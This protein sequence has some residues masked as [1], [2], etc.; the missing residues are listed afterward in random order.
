MTTIGE[1]YRAAKT[2]T[3]DVW[4]RLAIVY[5][6]FE[7]LHNGQGDALYGAWC[8]LMRAYSPSDQD[9]LEAHCTAAYARLTAGLTEARWYGMPTRRGQ[10][11][12]NDCM[13]F[14]TVEAA[15][16]WAERHLEFGEWIDLYDGYSPGYYGDQFP[17][18]RIT[19]PHQVRYE[20]P[21]LTLIETF[22]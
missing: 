17:D 11:E 5:A 19:A 21:D 9:L 18:L 2:E 22:S 13:A 3:D 14:E 16:E 4:E 7:S 15:Q 6:A 8:H 1:I 12:P 10:T 20:G